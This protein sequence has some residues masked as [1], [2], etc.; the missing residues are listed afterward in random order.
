MWVVLIGSFAETTSIINS[1]VKEVSD[2]SCSC[3]SDDLQ[4]RVSPHSLFRW[5]LVV[6]LPP[7]LC[8]RGGGSVVV[9][10]KTK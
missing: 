7:A 9:A 10:P 5:A 6:A 3:F 1:V 2:P 8:G 4:S